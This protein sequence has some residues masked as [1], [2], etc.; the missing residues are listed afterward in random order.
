MP[1]KPKQR[2]RCPGPI[3]CDVAFRCSKYQLQDDFISYIFL[4]EI[5]VGL[6]SGG[7]GFIFLGCILFFDRGLLALGNVSNPLSLP[8]SNILEAFILDRP[9]DGYRADEGSW[10]FC[11]ATQM[12]WDCCLLWRPSTGPPE[13]HIYR[14]PH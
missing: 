6:T 3:F 1:P 5:G 7:V 2:K 11:K 4:V 10:I 13:I 8:S 9:G 14:D 12:A